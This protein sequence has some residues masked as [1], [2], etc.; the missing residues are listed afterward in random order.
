MRGV[1]IYGANWATFDNFHERQPTTLLRRAQQ[2]RQNKATV[3][4]RDLGEVTAGNRSWA[5][6]R[7]H[8]AGSGFDQNKATYDN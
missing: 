4:A 8:R 6:P 2:D 5:A 3:A 7:D 1:K